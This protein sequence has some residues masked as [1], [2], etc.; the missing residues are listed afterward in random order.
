MGAVSDQCTAKLRHSPWRTG[1]WRCRN[2]AG[3]DGLCGVHRRRE[4]SEKGRAVVQE[5]RRNEA[6]EVRK[7]LSEAGIK[8]SIS[9]RNGVEIRLSSSSARKLAELLKTNSEQLLGKECDEHSG[10]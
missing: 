5:A 6:L 9:M 7:A 2:A 4:E 3:D 10:A 8:A 1:E